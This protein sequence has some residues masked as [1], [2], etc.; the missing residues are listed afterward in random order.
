MVVASAGVFKGALCCRMKL[1]AF[2]CIR[3]VKEKKKK[4]E[5]RFNKS[6]KQTVRR[7]D[8]INI[9]EETMVSEGE[10][11]QESSKKAK[12]SSP[13][14]AVSGDEVPKKKTISAGNAGRTLSES[15]IRQQ[16]GNSCKKI[17]DRLTF[18]WNHN[19]RYRYEYY[20]VFGNLD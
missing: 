3:A 13:K 19:G 2:Q 6:S 11:A 15:K 1:V 8:S 16:K 20:W 12:G 4:E 5:G 18:P 17:K 10:T 9:K 14:T 7:S